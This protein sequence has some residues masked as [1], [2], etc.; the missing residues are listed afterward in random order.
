MLGRMRFVLPMLML[1]LMAGCATSDSGS[2]PSG[3]D[4]NPHSEVLRERGVRPVLVRKAMNRQALLY[5]ELVELKAAGVTEE[6]LRGYID[7]ANTGYLMDEPTEAWLHE[8][9]FTDGFIL[10]LRQTG[11]PPES[12]P[13]VNRANEWPGGVADPRGE[14]PLPA[15]DRF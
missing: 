14:G 5:P 13:A 8:A 10:F 9:G 3:G 4:P 12:P 7:F 15:Y 2:L 11:M 6:E 1:G